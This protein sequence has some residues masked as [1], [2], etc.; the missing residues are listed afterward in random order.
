MRDQKPR[1]SLHKQQQVMKVMRR[2]SIITPVVDSR[3]LPCRGLRRKTFV[4]VKVHVGLGPHSHS[5][6]PARPSAGFGYDVIPIILS[7][8]NTE[9]RARVA[10]SAAVQFKFDPSKGFAA[11]C[12]KTDWRDNTWSSAGC[13]AV[14]VPR[15][16]GSPCC[17]WHQPASGVEANKSGWLTGF[18][19][20]FGAGGMFSIWGQN[21]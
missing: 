9:Q 12:V 17:H 5:L 15:A 6:T 18:C 20:S 21:S 4:C 8:W 2:Q 11:S 13:F 3:P 16:S 1:L 7:H 19:A 14:R 10:G